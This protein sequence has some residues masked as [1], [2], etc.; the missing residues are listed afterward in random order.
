TN[1]TVVVAYLANNFKSWPAWRKKYGNEL[2]PDVI[3][4]V[5]KLFATNDL[6]IVLNGHSGGGSFI[7]GYLDAM[8]TIPNEVVRI[9]FLDSDYAYERALGHKEK[10]ARWLSDGPNHCLCVVAYNDAAA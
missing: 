8:E 9:A 7:F 2:I 6:Q 5:K 1:E 10:L 3:N 4:S